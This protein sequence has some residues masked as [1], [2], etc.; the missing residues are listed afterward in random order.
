LG[1]GFKMTYRYESGQAI[2]PNVIEAIHFTGKVGFLSKDLWH[3]FFGIGSHRW[4]EQQLQSVIERGLLRKHR[5]EL[6]KRFWVLSDRG[7]ELLKQMK[8]AYVSP[9][10]V[11]HLG[12]DRVVARSMM[13]LQREKLIRGF[14]VERELKTYGVRDF[15][16]SDQDREP[17]YPDAVFKMEAFGGK[18]TVAIEYEK[19]R[20]S[21][22]RYKSI[23]F[24]YARITNL[25][26]ALF[27]VEEKGIRSAVEKAMKSLGETALVDKLAFV[28]SENW[29]KSPL[30]APISL[31]SGV[32]KL[33]EICTP[34]S[35]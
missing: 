13:R 27:I 22:G 20:K 29:Q 2:S 3:E 23:L 5:N 30:T 4:Q 18:R 12:H 26:M 32:V 35:V 21:H 25:S 1:D 28:N 31:K 17:K 15:L 34:M 7:V 16:L 10:P 8:G 24:Q 9:V 33:C 11:M 19:E 6:A 14:H